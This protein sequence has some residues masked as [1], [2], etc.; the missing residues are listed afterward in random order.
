MPSKLLRMIVSFH[1][2]MQDTVQYNES[3]SDPFPIKCRV[4]LGCVLT[5]THFGIFSLLLSYA[6]SQSEDGVY[7]HTKNNRTS[8]TF[9][10]SMQQSR[11]VE[12]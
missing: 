9:H 11:F 1:E 6:F 12:Y 10:D 4:E 5:P 3:S 7:L 8:S 2:D